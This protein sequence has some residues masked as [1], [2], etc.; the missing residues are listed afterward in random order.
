MAVSLDHPAVAEYLR[1]LDQAA[2]RLPAGRRGELI[3]EIRGHVSEALAAIGDDEAAVRGVLDRLGSPEEIVAAEDV[4]ARGA[5]P[6]ELHDHEEVGGA[7][8][9]YGHPR[10]GPTPGRRRHP[11]SSRR[12]SAP[13][14][15]PG[16]RWNVSRCSG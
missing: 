10:R 3:E 14:R 11:L 9:M 6:T 4:G 1:R 16:G 2:A 8:P 7:P 12:R 13:P 5:D 15:A